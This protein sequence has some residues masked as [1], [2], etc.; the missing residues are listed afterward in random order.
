MPSRW[1]LPLQGARPEQVKLEHLH[2]AVSRWFDKTPEQHAVGTKPYAI[3]PL[4]RDVDSP[5]VGFELATLTAETEECLLERVA[6][7][8]TVR[9]GTDQALLGRPRKTATEDWSSLATPS[10][11]RSWDLE[12]A[13]PVTF[14]RGNRASPLPVAGSVLRGLLDSWNCWSGMPDRQLTRQDTDEIW[15]SD[16]DGRSEPITVSGVRM[17]A[18][19]GRVR[20]RCDKQVI[21]D[22][23]DPLFRLAPYAGVGSAKA[24][25]LGVTRLH[26]AQ[27]RRAPDRRSPDH[28]A[29]AAAVG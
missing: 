20:F 17:S 19:V 14:R 2:A 25:G 28:R 15:V 5:G 12:F 22:L 26:G 18:F 24:K 4:A 1:W 3:S 27:D 29:R 8:A 23:V 21:A 11:A 7:P 10:G 16:I 9:L 13:T 6:P